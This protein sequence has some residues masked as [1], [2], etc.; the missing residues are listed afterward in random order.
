MR[1][2]GGVVADGSVLLLLGPSTGGIGTHVEAIVDD[3]VAVGRRVTVTGPQETLQLFDFHRRGAAVA[4]LP[5]GLPLL[6]RPWDC[7]ALRRFAAAHDV[8]HAHGLQ[9]GTVAALLTRPQRLVVTWHNAPLS[10]GVTAAPHVLLEKIA[11]R[12]SAVTIGASPDLVVRARRAGARDARFIPVAPLSMVPSDNAAALRIE[13][14]L[15]GAPVVLGLGRL[16]VQKRFDVLVDAAATW[17]DRSPRPAVVLAGDGPA[18]E[19]LQQQAFRLGVDL[20]LLGRRTDVADLLA[21]ADVVVLPSSWE[22]RPLAAQ[23]ALAAGRA[24]VATPVGGVPE[25]VGDAALLVPV[26]D[27]EALSVAVRSVLD[28]ADVRHRL[29]QA[30]LARAASWPDAHQVSA[31]LMA[32]YDELARTA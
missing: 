32:L 9:P 25:L 15:V 1:P 17:T 5:V 11:A 21:L 10:S 22:A 23:E 8:T 29:E 13:L 16:H 31:E 6:A 18:R 30:A 26:G 2:Y 7:R 27:A 14:G 4:A 3:C 24:L 12:R 19:S 20:R 28:D